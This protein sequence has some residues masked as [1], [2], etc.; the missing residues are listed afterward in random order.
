MTELFDDNETETIP[1]EMILDEREQMAEKVFKAIVKYSVRVFLFIF[2]IFVGLYWYR[3]I[4]FL[5]NR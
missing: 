4:K 2:L 1:E 3:Q 5:N